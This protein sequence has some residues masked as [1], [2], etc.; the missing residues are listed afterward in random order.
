MQDHAGSDEGVRMI[1]A[2]EDGV[3]KFRV[4]FDDSHEPTLGGGEFRAAIKVGHNSVYL[5]WD[6]NVKADPEYVKEQKK[7]EA[8]R[9]KAE[10]EAKAAE[11]KA[12]KEAKA[13]EEKAAK[14]AKA[15]EEKAAKEA[16]AAEEK[17]AAAKE[18][19]CCRC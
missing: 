10:K 13:A 16:K 14:E 6:V 7:L 15:A 4:I 5:L 2:D 19:G 3:M 18:K 8:E 12:A 9:V 17:A 1:E 11:E